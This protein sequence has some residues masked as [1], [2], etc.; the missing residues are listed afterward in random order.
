MRRFTTITIIACLIVLSAAFSCNKVSD[1]D[2][3]Q[4]D[5]DTSDDETIDDDSE[6]DDNDDSSPETVC[7]VRDYGASGD[8]VTLDTNA[9]QAAID[10]CTSQGGGRVLLTAGV[11]YSGSIYLRSNITLDLQ[12]GATLL[13][14]TD[15]NDYPS[16]VLL[17]AEG[18]NNI[19]IEG[20][21]GID[22]NGL[23]WWKR[24]LLGLWRPSRLIKLIDSRQIVI[25]DI[26]LR[27]S[28]KWTLHLL[29]C[30]QALIENVTIRNT[31]GNNYIS[32]NTDGIDLE[33]CRDV[34]ISHCDIETGDDCIALK[35]SD[36]QWRRESFNISVHDCLLAGWANG[37]KIGTE[38]ERDFH[39]IE[40]RDSTIRAS[41]DSNPGTRCISGVAIITDDGAN[42][43]DITV[44]NIHMSSVQ[45]PFFI[46]LQRRLRGDLS[47]PGTINNIILSNISVDDASL[48][49]SIQGIPEK[50]IDAV[51][52]K[53]I[54]IT[55]SEGGTEAE[56]DRFVPE[57]ETLYPDADNFGKYP[58]FG[59]FARHVNG[60]L[61]YEGLVTF[62]SLTG[63]GRP[64]VVYDDVIQV[65]DSGLT[66]SPWVYDR[67]GDVIDCE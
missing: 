45:A 8:G 39:D 25:R 15:K 61:R 40:F 3:D 57:R 6:D 23:F 62:T 26:T 13:G 52:L 22:G 7:A 67:T 18:V 21:G 10:D 32:P 53:N 41:V 47:A 35:N 1:D 37:F 46:R 65:D 12:S 58:A 49:A 60:C 33:G 2:D 30:D 29:A 11:Y 36:D 64:E 19:V 42:L 16:E 17:L 14:S 27:Q 28:P 24:N 63:D 51:R 59:L 54:S 44:D 43:R 56:K 9:I 34:E 20:D 31:V 55:S 48:T 66:G 5:D 38:T 50:N 4:I